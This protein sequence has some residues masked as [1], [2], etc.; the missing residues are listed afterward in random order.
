MSYG[1]ALPQTLLING[2]SSAAAKDLLTPLPANPLITAFHWNWLILRQH[3]SFQCFRDICAC[4]PPLRVS[5]FGQKLSLGSITYIAAGFGLRLLGCLPSISACVSG[6]SHIKTSPHYKLIPQPREG[7]HNGQ[8]VV[9]VTQAFPSTP[10][11]G[12]P[13]SN[14]ST[15][16]NLSTC[17]GPK[18]MYVL[19]MS[20]MTTPLLD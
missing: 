19:T 16:Q 20:G 3:F 13:V 1:R 15:Q 10:G 7:L 18:E 12:L 5:C 11:S 9:G 4:E 2:S 8:Y 6:W 17:P 14:E